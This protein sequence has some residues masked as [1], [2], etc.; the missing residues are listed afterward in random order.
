MFSF[1]G[2]TV[3]DPFVGSGTTCQ[4]AVQLGRNGVGIDIEDSFVTMT[5]QR[6]DTGYRLSGFY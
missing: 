5:K 3:L 1:M 6:L 2:D 4:A